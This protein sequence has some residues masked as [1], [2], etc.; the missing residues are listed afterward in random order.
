MQAKTRLLILSTL[1]L[2][3]IFTA[4]TK[5][6][7]DPIGTAE[8]MSTHSDDQSRFSNEMDAATRDANEAMEYGSFFRT[9][10][11]PSAALGCDATMTFDS[12]AD[13]RRITI[14]YNSTSCQNGRLRSGKLI[15]SIPQ[16]VRWRDAGAVVTLEFQNMTV[17]RTS[18]DKTITF[19]GTYSITNVTGGLLSE[20]AQRANIVH[21]IVSN[22]VNI[23]FDD[24]TQRTWKV[25]RRREFSYDNGIKVSITGLHTDGT[26]TNI[27]EWGTNRFGKA[28]STSI[29]SPLVVR[30]DCS[31]RLVS[32][33]I[34]HDRLMG[35]AI[36]VFGLDANGE[37]TNCPTGNYYYKLTWTGPG[38]MSYSVILP[39]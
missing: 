29:T 18:D 17:K 9:N 36:V 39:Y 13:A 7:L 22:N 34:R 14:T 37:S 16:N 19:N 3:L 27:S 31:F 25:A 12:L 11:P 2:S 10:T 23:L 1:S 35:N 5:E 6:M 4:C 26:T 33:A 24:G 32:G 8:E 20:L 38:G 30:Q 28:F 21:T 15:L